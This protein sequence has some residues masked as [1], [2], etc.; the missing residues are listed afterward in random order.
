MG[1]LRGSIS[2]SRF[3]VRGEMPASFHGPFL[4]AVRVRAFRP[5][6]AAEEDDERMG[7]CAIEEPFDLDLD[8]GK[9][10]SNEYL[11]LG[12]RVDRWMI[13]KPLFK[14]HFADAERAHLEKRGREKL[15][16][17]EKDE[18]KV[19]VGRRLRKQV[20]PAMRV[21]DLSWNLNAG[22]VR[23]WSRSQKSIDRLIE[24]FGA[25]FKLELVVDSPYVSATRLGLSAP[26]MKTL[27]DLEP[28]EL[29]P[30]EK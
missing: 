15:S 1:A 11:N 24:I 14:A 27:D 5:L 29:A 17:R 3:F 21:W 2:Y 9:V 20:L 23:F 18:L 16:R 8:H 30:E 7:W 4:K 19:F 12:L 22:V 10:F 28:A 26:L 25:T 13:P 6:E